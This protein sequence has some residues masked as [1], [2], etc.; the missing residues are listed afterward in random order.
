MS[1][2]DF[3]TAL[4]N[5]EALGEQHV[6]ELK[7][8]VQ[9][10]PWFA[11][12]HVM[13]AKA[14]HTAASPAY[15]DQLHLAAV[16]AGSRRVI[17]DLVVAK[18]VARGHVELPEAAEATTAPEPIPAPQVQP[19]A[20]GS[21]PAPV[22]PTPEVEPEPVAVAPVEETQPVVAAKT[23]TVAPE[24]DVVDETAEA[25]DASE[26]T[27]LPE[28]PVAPE[29][30]VVPDVA[31]LTDVA[32]VP[33][34]AEVVETEEATEVT[35]VEEVKR[36]LDELERAIIT[37]G[38]SR[39]IEQEV[40]QSDTESEAEHLQEDKESQP[41]AQVAK[42]DGN[43]SPFANWLLK[44]SAE[45]GYEV[46]ADPAEVPPVADLVPE[47]EDPKTKQAR[48]IASFIEKDPAITRGRVTDFDAGDLAQDSIASDES[49]V[50]ETMARI[51][52]KQGK[53]S[54]ARKAYQMLAL[55]YPEKSIYFAN[56]LKK[57]ERKK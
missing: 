37:A 1:P 32:V 44:R 7:A 4:L 40:G 42:E 52:A 34:A 50:T 10:H 12:G 8:L 19:E 35:Q 54:K 45:L 36:P 13:L 15:D 24:P 30:E 33:E 17:Y 49:L 26:V 27:E 46:D 51:Y 43:L 21:D 29:V 28:L 14:L 47:D 31:V 53:L 56:Q 41:Q 16:H 3:H 18:E 22:A 57:L 6:A 11:T 38:V 23:E 39:V 55:K 20:L 2:S 5:P 25:S 9:A 48:L